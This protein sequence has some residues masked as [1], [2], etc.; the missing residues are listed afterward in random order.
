MTVYNEKRVT[1]VPRRTNMEN[2]CLISCL[3]LPYFSATQVYSPSSWGLAFVSV[4]EALGDWNAS[5]ND[6][7]ILITWSLPLNQRTWFAFNT[8]AWIE[9]VWPILTDT[10]VGGSLN[11]KAVPVKRKH[12]F[13]TYE[14][15]HFNLKI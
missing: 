10:F 11:V 6:V 7:D 13:V 1:F 3:F 9:T 12:L 2:V 4:S 15:V 8:E 5:W 14:V